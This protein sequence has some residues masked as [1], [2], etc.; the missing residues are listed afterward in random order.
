ML[1]PVVN[2]VSPSLK[3]KVNKCMRLFDGVWG[4]QRVILLTFF[5]YLHTI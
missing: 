3:Y 4:L 1:I 2:C 5:C